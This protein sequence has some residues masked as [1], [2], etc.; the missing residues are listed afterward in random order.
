MQG[1]TVR[2]VMQRDVPTFRAETPFPTIM[3]HFLASTL[4]LSF[5]I[6]EH[7]HLVGVISIHDVK[8]TLQDD[9][10]GPSRGRG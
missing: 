8:S 9:H 10:L 2:Q 5:V 6:N 1:Y 3:D 7:R 4:P